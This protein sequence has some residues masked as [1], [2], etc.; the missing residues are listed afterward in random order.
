MRRVCKE[1]SNLPFDGG[2]LDLSKM[3]HLSDQDLR[4]I[5]DAV[6]KRGDTITSLNLK[7][8]YS[9]TDA[10]LA[11]LAKLPLTSLNLAGTNTLPMAALPTLL[12]SPLHL[13]I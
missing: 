5:L 3:S 8:C 1:W 2:D 4:N 7:S 9:I 10:A 12:S 13:L 6:E 11:H